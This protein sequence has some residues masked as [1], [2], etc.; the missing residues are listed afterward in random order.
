MKDETILDRISL[1][2]KRLTKIEDT[3]NKKIMVY[4]IFS[5]WLQELREYKHSLV[6][7]ANLLEKCKRK[8]DDVKKIV[9]KT[10][11]QGNTGVNM[12]VFRKI[13]RI[14]EENEK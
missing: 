5:L 10:L 14:L 8:I 13:L 2:E 7:M 1:L 9:Q 6:S 4:D 12:A 3:V 11:Q